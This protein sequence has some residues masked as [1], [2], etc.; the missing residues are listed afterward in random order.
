MKYGVRYIAIASGPI[1]NRKKTLLVGIIFRNSYIEG[2]LSGTVQKD[3]TDSTARIIRMI[4][5]SR[6]K[7]QIRILVFNGIA[8]A[9]LNIFD[10]DALEAGLKSSIV[11]MN[12]RRQNPKELVHALKEFSRIS[13][14]EV[15]ERIRIV[16]ES[17]AMRPVKINGL[18]LQSRLYGA[19][20]RDFSGRAFEALRV[21]HIVASGISTGESKGRL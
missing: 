15:K 9:G 12:R 8:L 19:Y 18:F 7:D 17:A 16:K 2:V 20:L 5:R 13:K 11:L 4:K 6:F 14:T 3:G 1:K 21:A 10:P